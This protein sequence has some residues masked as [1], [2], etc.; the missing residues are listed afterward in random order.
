VQDSAALAL[1]S[2]CARFSSTIPSLLR[3]PWCLKSVVPIRHPRRRAPISPHHDHVQCSQTMAACTGRGPS[4]HCG[5]TLQTLASMKAAFYHLRWRSCSWPTLAVASLREGCYPIATTPAV[6]HT[7]HDQRGHPL[8]TA[9]H[10]RGN[11]SRQ[12]LSSHCIHGCWKN[13]AEKYP[14]LLFLGA[15]ARFLLS[16]FFAARC[17]HRKPHLGSQLQQRLRRQR[18]RHPATPS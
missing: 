15:N 17:C 2:Q 16:C 14:A 10:R 9:V 7:R 3:V 6:A 18:P 11:P 4:P 13:L 1:L 8:Q 12:T 5:P